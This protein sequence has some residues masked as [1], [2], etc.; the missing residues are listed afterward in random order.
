M[1]QNDPAQTTRTFLAI[2]LCMAI[3]VG[4]EFFF[5]PKPK[6]APPNP[7][8]IGPTIGP[9]AETDKDL[10]P[11]AAEALAQAPATAAALA[12]AVADNLKPGAATPTAAALPPAEERFDELGSSDVRATL[13]NHGAFAT[14]WLWSL[15]SLK[16]RLW[17]LAHS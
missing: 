9:P 3:L 11:P 2:A 7:P 8:P 1:Q 6:Q 10:A 4:W 15:R 17:C 5:G 12:A 14:S 13:T 16:G